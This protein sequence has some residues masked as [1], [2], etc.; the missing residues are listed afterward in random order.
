MEL[1]ESRYDK[2][3]RISLI[4]VT[5]NSEKFI[6]GCIR[7]VLIELDSLYEYI[8]I[9]NNSSDDTIKIVQSFIKL[10][11]GKLKI[12]S[13]PDKGTYDAI[14]K[15]IMMSTGN[16]IGLLHSDIELY[17]KPLQKI[18]EVFE[19]TNID[20]LYANAISYNMSEQFILKSNSNVIFK[21]YLFMPLLH[22]TLY[23]KADLAKKHLYSM[24]YKISSD[25]NLILLLS[26]LNLSSYYY[27]DQIILIHPNGIT[28]DY[29]YLGVI[30]MIQIN[31]RNFG[32]Y[33]SLFLNISLLLYA[34]YLYFKVRLKRWL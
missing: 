6:G 4:T 7:S 9:D 33:K 20:Y 24:E 1:E 26:N 11:R 31:I 27:D 25:Y 17:E 10:F 2:S 21:P 14:N 34:V 5:F 22:N 8:I 32:Y 13:E 16:I 30:E 28:K 23:I 19:G 15:G 29:P 3:K 12:I 18:I